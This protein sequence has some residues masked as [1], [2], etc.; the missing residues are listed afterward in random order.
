MKKKNVNTIP[1]LISEKGILK[2]GFA[3]LTE[4][5]MSRIG[6]GGNNRC[7]NENCGMGSNTTCTNMTL[8]VPTS[9]VSGCR[10]LGDCARMPGGGTVIQ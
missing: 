10:N 5:Q 7:S 9:N 8:C 6:G 2:G 3:A 1:G 4:K